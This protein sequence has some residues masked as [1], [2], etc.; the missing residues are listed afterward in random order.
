MLFLI[1]RLVKPALRRAGVKSQQKSAK[2]NKWLLQAIS[3]VKEVKVA[4]EEEYFLNQFSKYEDNGF[5][6]RRSKEL[7]RRN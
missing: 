4:E 3:R 5:Y 1:G 6:S 7:Y 2:M